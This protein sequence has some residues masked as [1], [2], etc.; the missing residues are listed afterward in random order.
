M[1]KSVLNRCFDLHNSVTVVN[2]W[3][4]FATQTNAK[5]IF[6]VQIPHLEF[7]STGC[8]NK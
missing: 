6:L 2:S 8:D 4:S 7:R 3:S 1:K 5:P